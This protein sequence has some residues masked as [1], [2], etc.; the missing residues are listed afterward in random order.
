M[1]DSDARSPLSRSRP[2]RQTLLPSR[3]KPR[4][5]VESPMPSNNRDT[6]PVRFDES[7]VFT[8][9]FLQ[10]QLSVLC[11]QF[12]GSPRS[13]CR[14]QIAYNTLQSGL[15]VYFVYSSSSL[16]TRVRCAWLPQGMRHRRSSVHSARRREA[17]THPSSTDSP[18]PRRQEPALTQ[19]LGPAF[20]RSHEI[21]ASMQTT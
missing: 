2:R 8:C 16:P 19:E 12:C 15:A 18:H 7:H 11:S 13:P 4:H 10:V 3:Q 20:I 6:M 1:P 5:T 17:G 21:S 9:V 14:S